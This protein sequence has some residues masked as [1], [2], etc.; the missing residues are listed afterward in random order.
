MEKWLDKYNTGGWLDKYNDGGAIQENYNDS[1]VSLPEGFVGMGNDTTGRNYSPA[2]NGQFQKGG[3]LPPI[4]VTNPNDPRLKAYKDSSVLSYKTAWE[5]GDKLTKQTDA[6]NKY[7]ELYKSE[8]P[9]K[10][11]QKV[12]KAF[13]DLA[14]NNGKNPTIITN[15]KP[16]K[17]YGK[18]AIYHFSI[19]VQPVILQKDYPLANPNDYKAQTRGTITSP[20]QTQIPQPQG[21]Y[22]YGPSNSVIGVSN[23]GKFSPINMPDQRGQV[24]NPD[25]EMLNNPEALK[26]YVTQKGF[27]FQMG[28]NLPKAQ[29]GLWA[30]DKRGYTDSVL[31]A[32]K[33]LDWVKRLYDK[34]PKAMM[35]PGEKSSSTHLMSDDDQGYVFPSIVNINGQLVDLGNRAEDYARE[36]NTGIQFAKE[37]GTWFARSTNDKS[38]YKMGTGVLKGKPVMQKYK[39]IDKKAM[40][41]NISGSVGNM[42][43]RTGAPSKGPRRNQTDVTDASAQNGAEMQFYQNGLDWQPRNISKNGS[44]IPRAQLGLT[45]NI[46]GQYVD[47]TGKP[48]GATSLLRASLNNIPD[49]TSNHTSIKN[50]PAVHDDGIIAATSQNLKENVKASEL[51]RINRATNKRQFIGQG[52]PE[53]IEEQRINQA[54]K[55]QYVNEHP[56]ANLV[57]GQLETINPYRNLEGTAF[58]HTP[59]AKEDRFYN[60]AGTALD[61]AGYVTGAGELIGAAK[62]FIKAELKQVG[63][64]LTEETALKNAYKLNPARFKPNPEAYYRMIG[65]EGFPDA[66]KSGVIRANPNNIH[67]WDG[68]QIYN[69]PYFS[70][71]I[72]LDRNWKSPLS[73]KVGSIYKGPDMVEV[74]DASK[75]KISDSFVSSPN[76]ELSSFDPSVKFYKENWLKGYKPIEVPKPTST[77][78]IIS[79]G[80]GMDAVWDE[81]PGYNDNLFKKQGYVPPT[82][83]PKLMTTQGRI[84]WNGVN[85]DNIENWFNTRPTKTVKV[86]A[87][88]ISTG[89]ITDITTGINPSTQTSTV[90][91]ELNPS[92]EN[93]VGPKINPEQW[94]DMSGYLQRRQFVKNLQNEGLVGKDFNLGDVNYTARSTDKTNALTKLALERRHTGF[95]NVKGELPI[96]G[97]GRQSYTGQSYDMNTP[98]FGQTI[99]EM[100]NMKNAGVDFNNPKSIAEYQATHIPLQDYG[101]RSTGEQPTPD[102]GFI[103]RSP[104]PTSTTEY[105]KFQFKSQPNLDFTSGN[106]EDWLK[107]YY[108]DLEYHLKPVDEFNFISRNKKTS[109]LSKTAIWKKDY[110]PSELNST[111]VGPRGSKAFEIDKTFQFPNTGELSPKQLED[112]KK[113]SEEY[114]NQYNTGWRG[115][116]KQG[117]IIKDDRGQWDHPGEITEIQGDTMATHGYGNI[118]LYVVP[119][120]GQPRIVQPN[121]GTQK[122]K[123]ARKFTEYPIAKNGLRQEQKGL[124]NLDDLVNFTNYNKP[125]TKKGW[126]DK[127]Q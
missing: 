57:N 98:A 83:D 94:K 102:Y 5:S 33:N 59:A 41:G 120:R 95:R 84:D 82:T 78:E 117:G 92:V 104:N 18:R 90:G 125:T 109:D 86:G 107:Q 45:K 124:Q 1:S 126:L 122:F 23:N 29:N 40:G 108:T 112:L 66:M 26:K 118:P 70:K 37:Q 123:G 79:T 87:N 103:F 34:N 27:K 68:T 21:D 65:K 20:Q 80:S 16:D 12:V 14:Y 121:T 32:N 69:E 11:Y 55:Q 64:Y 74:N 25:L 3:K 38:G 4:N 127:Y 8:A 62:P 30:T 36:T 17:E 119:D 58:P 2:W 101:Y 7:F 56:N 52:R 113:Y 76:S 99:S 31:N 111:L 44:E 60:D 63:K 116:Y 28:G 96:D 72:P 93:V 49:F 19:P 105:G 50:I 42:Y 71:G 53:S 81:I 46:L 88:N 77:Q 73:K 89:N 9:K 75:F 110:K 35:V 61:M 24:N 15:E 114:K 54:R 67:P 115:Q 13:G 39:S 97:I 91:Y 22:V 10:E 100:E 43:A 48:P 106:H 51:N 85:Y 6:Q 47:A